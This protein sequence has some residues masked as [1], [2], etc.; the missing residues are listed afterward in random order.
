MKILF[1][2]G[3][4]EHG[5]DGVGDYTRRLAEEITNGENDAFVIAI[6][7]SFVLEEPSFEHPKF[8]LE[9]NTYRIPASYPWNKRMEILQQWIGKINPDWISLQYVPFAYQAKGL[10]F[11]LPGKLKRISAGI[12]WHIMFHELWVGNRPFKFAILAQLQ[13]ALISHMI[14]TMKAD[15]IHTHLPLYY[16][17]LSRLSVDVKE[18]PLFSNFADNLKPVECDSRTMRV[19]FFNLVNHDPKITT[20]VIELNQ[21]C[22]NANLDFE[23]LLIGG[24]FEALHEFGNKLEKFSGLKYKIRYAGFL[25]EDKVSQVLRTCSLGV[26]P[27]S[28]SALGKS[29]TAAAFLSHG[30]P[31]AVPISDNREKPFFDPAM[32]E[33]IVLEPSLAKIR[34][35]SCAAKRLKNYLSIKIIAQKFLKDLKLKNQQDV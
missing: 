9:A 20:F 1:L 25:D 23:V 34:L 6:N 35:A 13:K 16:N 11:F 30:I 2:C 4:L 33:A 17:D 31:V 12:R 26:S 28:L 14:R 5:R 24:A 18:L 3:S 32:M 29:G 7:D 27:L 10:P 19:A 22:V 15:V 8:N 21:C